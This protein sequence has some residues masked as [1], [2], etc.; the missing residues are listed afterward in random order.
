MR[1]YSIC[2]FRVQTFSLQMCIIGNLLFILISFLTIKTLLH[3]CLRIME[4]MRRKYRDFPYNLC[5]IQPSTHDAFVAVDNLTLTQ[6]T[7]TLKLHV[8]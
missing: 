1:R 3:S 2:F 5:C 7:L 4:N 6:P 8:Y